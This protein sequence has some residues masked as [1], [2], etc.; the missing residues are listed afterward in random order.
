MARHNIDNNNCSRPALAAAA[1]LLLIL[2]LPT[3]VAAQEEVR[4]VSAIEDVIVTAQRRDDLQQDVPV[5]ISAFGSAE[6]NA[7][8]IGDIGDFALT[9]PS[10][11]ITPFLGDKATLGVFIRGVGND[12]PAQ[13]TRDPAVG[14]YLNGIYIARS[15]GLTS[16][17]ADLE[18]IEVLRG[19]QGALY[20][21]NT[22]GGA[23][24]IV[25][26][27]PS[28]QFGFKETLS[29]G[30]LDYVRSRTSVNLPTV[31]KVSASLSYLVESR[32]GWVKNPGSGPDFNE[33]KK[34]GAMLALNWQ[35]LDALTVDYTFDWSSLGGTPNYYQDALLYPH[36]RERTARAVDKDTLQDSDYDIQGHGVVAEWQ[37]N[38]DLALK[39]LTGYRKMDSKIFQDFGTTL[40]P[41]V[42][43]VEVGLDHR[44]V[45]QELQLIGAALDG[46]LEYIAGAYY[47]EERARENEI[48]KFVGIM[49]GYRNVHADNTSKS[50]FAQAAYTPAFNDNLTLTVGGR[51]SED[52]REARRARTDSFGSVIPLERGSVDSS[53]FDPS[54][55]LQYKWSD[56][57]SS[58]AKFTTA[59]RSAGFS[60]RS[61]TFEPFDAEKLTAYELGI[62][63]ALF[64]QRLRLNV[65]AFSSHFTDMQ[66]DLVVDITRPDAPMVFNAGKSTI[67]GVE[68]DIAAVPIEGLEL[69]LHYT[70]LDAEYD[71]VVNPVSG[72][73]ETGNFKF[74]QPENSYSATASYTFPPLAL[75][76][77]VAN[78]SY[79]WRDSYPTL[80]YAV[81]EEIED[82]ALLDANLS[83]MEIPLGNAWSMN[84]ALWGKNLLDEDYTVFRTQNSAAHGDPRSYGIE[85]HFQY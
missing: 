38:D 25:S 41:F 57:V 40:T 12:D 53:Y 17:I 49:T 77:L 23:V 34:Q 7:L 32:D 71:R 59:H 31:A 39:S 69:G 62:K 63:T 30:N 35:P 43:G 19:P 27:R 16:E 54:V 42:Y 13:P 60:T 9:V 70:Y 76:V 2:S 47:F 15:S 8:G 29:F 45:S 52:E 78:L 68:I 33:D 28:G 55:V 1:P 48:S 14:V 46:R 37:I 6:L 18:R 24:N 10:L 26:A 82:Y 75:G 56:S 4:R 5:A 85:L 20:G 58:Y 36:R 21:R 51:Y 67:N 80:G 84:V 79:S 83:L 74:S 3:A 50:V 64:E 44:Q 65:A 73:N 22:T 66:I 11:R 61:L 81:T 72:I